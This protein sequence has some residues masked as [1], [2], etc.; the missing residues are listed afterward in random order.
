MVA[1]H[2][3]SFSGACLA[4]CIACCSPGSSRGPCT[5]L[6]QA[7]AVR[8]Y[9]LFSDDSGIPHGNALVPASPSLRNGLVLLSPTFLLHL[10]IFKTQLRVTS[11]EKTCISHTIKTLCLGFFGLCLDFHC[12]YLGNI[13]L[14]PIFFQTLNVGTLSYSAPLSFFFFFLI[15]SPVHNR[16][17]LILN[18]RLV[19]NR[20]KN[21]IKIP[22]R[23]KINRLTDLLLLLLRWF[24]CFLPHHVGS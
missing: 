10:P 24:V 18:W 19:K 11:S 14:V 20:N 23:G 3:N 5:D 9:L 17:S 6:Q 4:D 8:D 1:R 7:V 12:R 13:L 15:S 21:M 2:E 22:S 16:F